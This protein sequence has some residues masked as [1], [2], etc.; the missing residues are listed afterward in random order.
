MSLKE[1]IIVV[2]EEVNDLLS[3][4]SPIGSQDFI[5]LAG[6][7]MDLSDLTSN[8]E[9]LDQEERNEVEFEWIWKDNII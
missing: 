6:R 9:R 4:E 2:A 3:K 5:K 8:L 7:L 1:R